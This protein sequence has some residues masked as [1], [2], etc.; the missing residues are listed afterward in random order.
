MEDQLP[1]EGRG[2]ERAL[3]R[4]GGVAREGTLSPTAQVVAEVGSVIVATGAVFPT[5]TTT[6]A[7]SVAPLGSATRSPTVTEPSCVY[8]RVG[9]GEVESSNCPSP[10]RSHA[11]VSVSPF[12]SLEPVPSKLTGS[13]AT[14]L[15][16]VAVAAAIGGWFVAK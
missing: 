6:E 9:F 10:S 11:Y 2:R 13:G 3:L 8:V 16:G 14:P 4:V 7:T 1:E 5:V 12:G 15:D